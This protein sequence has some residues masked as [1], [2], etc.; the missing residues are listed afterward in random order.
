MD[1]LHELVDAVAELD[2]QRAL[3][4]VERALAAGESPLELT[5][6]GEH[7]MR[8]VGERYE[9]GVYFL[10]G[11]IMAGEIFKGIMAFVRPGLEMELAGDAS[12]RVLLGTV[13]GDIHDIGKNIVTM[14]LRGFGFTV[15]DLGVD[16]SPERFAEA[17]RSFHPDIIGLSGL[18]STSYESM[19]L[20]IE[21]L[22]GDIP[23]IVGGVAVNEQVAE[24]T[25]ADY[26]TNDAMEGVRICERLRAD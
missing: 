26:W 12:G 1:R 13:A 5:R 24:F 23:I 17:A 14:A 7:G 4:I 22:R 10:S 19:R 8:R 6:A 25:G 21:A 2:E 16:V 11:L 15:E 20:A 3:H 18:T 9:Q